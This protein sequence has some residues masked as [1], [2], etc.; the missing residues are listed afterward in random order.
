M[1]AAE[2]EEKGSLE[3]IRKALEGDLE[4]ILQLQAAGEPLSARD[5]GVLERE[6]ARQAAGEE[7]EE[8]NEGSDLALKS[9]LGGLFNFATTGAG[10]EAYG[11]S[12]RQVKN[13]KREGRVRGMPCPLEEPAKMPA[14]FEAVFAPRECPQ[15]LR[16]AVQRLLAEGPGGGAA[17]EEPEKEPELPVIPPEVTDEEVGF[18]ATLRR[19]LQREA[20]LDKR[21]QAAILAGDPRADALETQWGKAASRVRELEKAAPAILEAQG[22]YLRRA[23]VKRELVGL[24]VG[25][26]KAVKQGL[27]GRRRELLEALQLA[28]LEALDRAL[29]DLVAEVFADLCAARFADPLELEMAG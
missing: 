1:S 13:W 23:E 14:W 16:D 24:A 27:R 21:L 20:L 11:Y 9:D 5:R 29:E 2:G 8:C 22:V 19:A 4:R 17:E 15:R 25:L 12:L 6:L 18:E 10:A 26:P 3:A 28:E 7:P